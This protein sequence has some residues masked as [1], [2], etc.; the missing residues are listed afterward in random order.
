M[1][2]LLKKKIIYES[3]SPIWLLDTDDEGSTMLQYFYIY[4]PVDMA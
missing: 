1:A 4:L 2:T 3:F